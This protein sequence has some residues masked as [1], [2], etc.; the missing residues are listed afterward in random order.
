MSR[1]IKLTYFNFEGSGEQVRLAFALSGTKYDDVRVDYPDG[2]AVLKP[3]LPFGQVPVITVDGG[4]MLAQSGAILRWIG[5]EVSPS[6]YPANKM[7]EVD[8]AL[9]L[10]QDMEDSWA[11]C[12]FMNMFPT[13]YGHAE[14]FEKTEQCKEAVKAMRTDWIGKELPRFAKY[15]VELMDKNGGGLWLASPDG[16]TIADCKLIPALRSFTRGFYD[17]VSPQCLDD[18]PRLVEYIKRF[19]ALKE[20]KG[21]YSDVH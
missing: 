14:G 1:S 20:V 6:L 5:R 2:W 17:H 16:P 21:R 11:P 18:Y 7:S 4:P 8:E 12:L 19:C 13:K 15:F 9:G 3:T 10:V